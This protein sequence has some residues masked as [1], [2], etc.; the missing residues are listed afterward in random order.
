MKFLLS[1]AKACHKA[2]YLG[3]KTNLTTH[4]NLVCGTGVMIIFVIH[5]TTVSKIVVSLEYLKVGIIQDH[6]HA[7]LL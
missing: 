6:F 4:P 3:W 1:V 5:C 7:L 2:D